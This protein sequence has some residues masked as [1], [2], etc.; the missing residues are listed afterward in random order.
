[1]LSATRDADAWT[2]AAKVRIARRRL[3]LCMRQE[4]PNHRQSFAECNGTRREG[5]P[6]IPV[7]E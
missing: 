3:N 5:V 7:S 1:M 4:S 2:I 6:L